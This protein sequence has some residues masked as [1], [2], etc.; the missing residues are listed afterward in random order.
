MVR[1]LEVEGQDPDAMDPEVWDQEESYSDE[2]YEEYEEDLEQL[3]EEYEE[4][5][6]ENYVNWENDDF[7]DAYG[8]GHDDEIDLDE[9]HEDVA[10]GDSSPDY[11]F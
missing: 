8:E 3:P 5:D 10:L 1:A 9:S 7:V 6:E 11:D 2:E 4:E